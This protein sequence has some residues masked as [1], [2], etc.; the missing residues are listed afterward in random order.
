MYTCDFV[1]DWR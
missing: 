1:S